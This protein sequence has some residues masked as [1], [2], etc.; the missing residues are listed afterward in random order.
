MSAIKV[1]KQNYENEVIN[2]D[3]P[4]ILDFWAGWCGPCQMLTPII[5]EIAN[6]SGNQIKVGKVN[7]DEENELASQFNVMSIPTILAIKDGEV[8]D[9]KVGV[10]AKEAIVG[11]VS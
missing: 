3:K 1:T 11:M 10:Q 5:D 4:V 2:S 7:I 8:I 6:E 9:K